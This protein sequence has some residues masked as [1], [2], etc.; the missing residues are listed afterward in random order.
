MRQLVTG[1]DER[2]RSRVVEEQEHSAASD[3]IGASTVY[4]TASNPA[5]PR[6]PGHGEHL[7]LGAA[8]GIARML[9]VQFPPGSRSQMHHT[10]TV[11][12]DT[13]IDGS[14]DLVLDDGRHHLEPGD[15]VVMTGV[16]HAWEAGPAGATMSVVALGTPTLPDEAS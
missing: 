5:P 6:P 8:V 4:Q 10:D 7:D 9:V 1:V 13:V 2:G 12:F 16:D 15:V 3:H 11:D 14:L